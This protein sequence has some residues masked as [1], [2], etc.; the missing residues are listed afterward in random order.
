MFLTFEHLKTRYARVNKESEKLLTTA[1]GLS[2]HL[3]KFPF[4]SGWLVSDFLICPQSAREEGDFVNSSIFLSFYSQNILFSFTG[5]SHLRQFRSFGTLAG[6]SGP[7]RTNH[8][9]RGRCQTRNVPFNAP[10]I[11]GYAARMDRGKF[12][13]LATFK[14][15]IQKKMFISKKKLFSCASDYSNL[16]EGYRAKLCLL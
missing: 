11:S 14:F 1:S 4:I 6:C 7:K 16:S 13:I 15:H 3:F 12:K 8:N 10:Y 2:Y 9:K 5:L